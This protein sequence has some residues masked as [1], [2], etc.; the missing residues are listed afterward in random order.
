MGKALKVPVHR[1]VGGCCQPDIPLEWSVSLADDPAVMVAEATR[2]VSEFGIRVLCLK[3]ADRRGWQQ[4]VK[5]FEIVRRALGDGIQIGVD[6]KT[7]GDR[8]STRLN[9]SH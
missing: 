2:A 9:S 4:D 7:G 5:N 3:A 1:L 6:P 8:K